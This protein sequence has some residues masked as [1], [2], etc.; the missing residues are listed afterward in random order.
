MKF[1]K[2]HTLKESALLWS[3]MPT[4]ESFSGYDIILALE[5][6]TLLLVLEKHLGVHEDMWFRVVTPDAIVG[7]VYSPIWH[8]ELTVFEELGEQQNH[9]NHNN[10]EPT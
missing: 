3:G 7:F 5:T 8:S 6:G 1:G 4:T 2:L 10:T 9:D